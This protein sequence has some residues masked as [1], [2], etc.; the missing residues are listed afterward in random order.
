MRNMA[1]RIVLL[2]A[3][4]AALTYAGL[5]VREQ[6]RLDRLAAERDAAAE[7]NRLN[8]LEWER[9]QR[10]IPASRPMGKPLPGQRDT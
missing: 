4:I 1:R 9:Q 7:Q 3:S 8:Y 2:G 10:A 6:A 5:A